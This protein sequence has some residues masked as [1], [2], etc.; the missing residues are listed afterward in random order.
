MIDKVGGLRIGDDSNEYVI[1]L[2]NAL[3]GGCKPQED[4]IKIKKAMDIFLEKHKYQYGI[5]HVNYKLAI[6]KK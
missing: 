1:A 6:V 2:L 5:I 3:K 4:G